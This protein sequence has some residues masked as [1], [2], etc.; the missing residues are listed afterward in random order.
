MAS[1]LY[2]DR[3]APDQAKT[4]GQA[5]N[6]ALSYGLGL[7]VGFFINGYVYE[8]TGS[9]P[10]FLMSALIALAGGMLF[11]SFQLAS[12]GRTDSINSTE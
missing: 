5:V 2:I 8:I 9:H 3:L 1:I 10:L 11:Q 12:R 7:M 6:N 4:L